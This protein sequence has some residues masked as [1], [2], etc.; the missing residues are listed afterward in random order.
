[1]KFGEGDEDDLELGKAA[2]RWIDKLKG[3]KDT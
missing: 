3:K 2:L 1:M